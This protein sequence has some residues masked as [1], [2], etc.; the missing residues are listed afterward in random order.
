MLE[1]L[2]IGG[3]P[4]NGSAAAVRPVEVIGPAADDARDDGDAELAVARGSCTATAA[5]ERR[6]P[7]LSP[8][9]TA[10]TAT[11]EA[12]AAPVMPSRCQRVSRS[13]VERCWG[14]G[15]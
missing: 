12:A 15:T 2:A 14:G 4:G 10:R 7:P 11:T 3:I 9:P 6:C 8:Q 5:D 1:L 13:C